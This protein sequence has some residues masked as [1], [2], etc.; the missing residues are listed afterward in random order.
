MQKI[1]INQPEIHLIGIS[2]RT[3]NIN[4]IN[5]ET[6][7]I[8]NLINRYF[9]NQ[10]ATKIPSRKN[11]SITYAVYTDYASDEFDDYTY[12][13]GEE[14]SSLDNIPEGFIA[15]TLQAGQYV[16]F[17]TPAGKLPGV[18]INAWM[19]IWQMSNE[20]LGGERTY[21]TDY[22]IYDVRATDPNNAVVDIFVGVNYIIK[23]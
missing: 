6:A 21:Q 20:E 19:E 4:E 1:I 10:L 23:S 5:Q 11:P 16:K 13:F 14:V 8:S 12:F 22:E 18:V 2:V 17:T 7:Q 15:M 3:N 9:Q